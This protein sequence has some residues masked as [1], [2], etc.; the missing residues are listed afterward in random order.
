[1]YYILSPI[2]SNVN[3]VNFILNQILIRIE[4]NQ[5]SCHLTL[6]RSYICLSAYEILDKNNNKN[7]HNK[8][9]KPTCLTEYSYIY[10]SSVWS[11]LLNSHL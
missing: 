6:L 9:L 3:M 2:S 1:M 4:K 10:Y 5:S 11:S 7:P 8:Y